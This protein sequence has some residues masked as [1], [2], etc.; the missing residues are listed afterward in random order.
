[1]CYSPLF[2][3]QRDGDIAGI[4]IDKKNNRDDPPSE[5]NRYIL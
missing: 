4:R 2:S 1:M 5:E 3:S